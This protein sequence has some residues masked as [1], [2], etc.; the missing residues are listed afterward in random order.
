MGQR[1]EG[2]P[3]A[4]RADSPERLYTRACSKSTR[5]SSPAMA[6]NSG[7]QQPAPRPIASSGKR[8][9]FG[10]RLSFRS[11]AAKPPQDEAAP[12]PRAPHSGAASAVAQQPGRLPQPARL[13]APH[14][15]CA[16][17]A[18][19]SSQQDDVAAFLVDHWISSRRME[20]QQQQQKEEEEQQ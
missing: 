12:G 5:S 19:A 3:K 14:E 15:R 4:R 13:P 11:R 2:A 1:E 8:P 9:S 7:S 10:L 16:R 18:N 17:T 6:S 20:Q